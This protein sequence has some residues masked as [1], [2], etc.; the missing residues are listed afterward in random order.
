MQETWTYPSETVW[1]AF[2]VTVSSSCV[3]L[4]LSGLKVFLALKLN[5][6]SVDHRKQKVPTDINW[7]VNW[8]NF[9]FRREMSPH[10]TATL[11][12]FQSLSGVGFNVLGLTTI[13]I[14]MLRIVFF[15][16]LQSK[17]AV[18]QEKWMEN[19]WCWTCTES[20]QRSTP[21][22]LISRSPTPFFN[23]SVHCLIEVDTM[24]FWLQPFSLYA[25]H[26]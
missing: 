3:V 4:G 13:Y 7:A 18:W 25:T 19:Q 6:D 9:P 26:R 1:L 16:F 20:V 11:S 17:E 5:S 2:F 23:T 15:F 12:F 24:D 10:S 21:P 22:P 14:E 8:W